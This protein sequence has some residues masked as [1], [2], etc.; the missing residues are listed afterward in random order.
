MIDY[1]LVFMKD[2]IQKNYKVI[3]AS[4]GVLRPTEEEY[5]KW[6]DEQIKEDDQTSTE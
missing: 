2:W 1:P 3:I 6:I 5:I 4:G